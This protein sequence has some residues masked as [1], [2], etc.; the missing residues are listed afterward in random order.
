MLNVTLKDISC[1]FVAGYIGSQLEI[2]HNY[3][4]AAAGIVYVSYL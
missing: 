3:L 1:L 2:L 4:A